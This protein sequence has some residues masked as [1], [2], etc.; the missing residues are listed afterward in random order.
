VVAVSDAPVLP[1]APRP[2][3]SDRLTRELLE[4]IRSSG[5]G[6]GE[7]LPA[8][9]ALAARFAVATPTVREAVRRLQA[10]GVLD[11]RHGSG[12][13]VRDSSRRVLLS[14]PY[15]GELDP[16]V[17]VDLLEARLLI[18]PELARR[19]AARCDE[20]AAAELAVLLVEAERVLEADDVLLSEVN[21]RFHRA[22]ARLAGNAILE[23]T[24]EALL[25]LYANERLAILQ[26]FDDRERDHREHMR[27][28]DALGARD[29][30]AAAELMRTHLD[31]VRKVLARRLVGGG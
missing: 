18:E 28:L 26:L 13:F 1:A 20:A 15:S 21:M 10:L 16:A 31:G 14:N 25:D 2:S 27:I 12:V 29:G 23:Q 4:L 24:M 9:P 19:A 8:L 11:V 5:L 22:I 17:I 3:Q 7:R 30:H 6:P